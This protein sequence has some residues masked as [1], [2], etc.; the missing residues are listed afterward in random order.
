V[1]ARSRLRSDHVVAD[2]DAVEAERDALAR[3]SDSARTKLR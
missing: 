1:A 3:R 2:V